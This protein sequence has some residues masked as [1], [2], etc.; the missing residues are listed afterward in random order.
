[1]SVIENKNHQVMEKI[2]DMCYNSN[3]I[4]RYRK[5]VTTFDLP[6]FNRFDIDGKNHIIDEI[7]NN[8]IN[9]NEPEEKTLNQSITKSILW[10]KKLFWF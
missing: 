10:L 6:T 3:A 5:I 8:H 2:K 7:I 9:I 1:M 4:Q